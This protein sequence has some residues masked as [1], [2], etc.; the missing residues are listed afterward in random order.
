GFALTVE[1]EGG[2]FLDLVKARANWTLE[3]RSIVAHRNRN[4]SLLSPMASGNIKLWW[5]P[6]EGLEFNVGYDAMLFFNTM[7][8]RHPIDFDF[9]PITPGLD[10]TVTRFFH[11]LR[12][13][14]SVTF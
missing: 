14:F 2:L 12:L 11:G 5:F 9:S 3:D 4:F 10:K 1:G 6:I 7:A 13:G 8:N